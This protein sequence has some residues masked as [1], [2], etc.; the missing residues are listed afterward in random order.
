MEN[1]NDI[2]QIKQDILIVTIGEIIAAAVM[3]GVYFLIRKM[4]GLVAIGA[5]IGVLL[6]VG[7]YVFMAAGVLSAAKKAEAGDELGAK[8]V[9]TL[10]RLVRYLLLFG[11][12][13]AVVLSKRFELPEMIAVLV[14][15]VLFRPIL[16]LGEFFRKK[17]GGEK[18][19]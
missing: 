10:S 16:S 3:I 15:L 13:L 2:R 5:A 14:P 17:E 9:L 12:L 11:I 19:N 4:S 7:N 1:M 18:E 8:R 6:A